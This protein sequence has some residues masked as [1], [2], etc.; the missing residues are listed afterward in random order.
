MKKQDLKELEQIAM[1][2][3]S[4]KDERLQDLANKLYKIYTNL[5]GE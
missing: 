1:T 2:L 5:G 4:T 3:L